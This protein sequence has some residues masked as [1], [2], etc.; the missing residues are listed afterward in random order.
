MP[1]V[2][3]LTNHNPY[4][5]YAANTYATG[6]MIRLTLPAK[7]GFLRRRRDCRAAEVPV[8]A[9]FSFLSFFALLRL[10]LDFVLEPFFFFLL[11]RR[12]R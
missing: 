10:L 12:R 7:R 5:C 8:A 9:A 3:Q 4:F 2:S 6:F 11:A 1:N